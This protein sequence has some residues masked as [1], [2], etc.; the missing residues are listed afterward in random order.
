MKA[1]CVQQV[2]NQEGM[3]EIKLASVKAAVDAVI[4][5]R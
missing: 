2:A 5:G 1:D 3:A 4:S